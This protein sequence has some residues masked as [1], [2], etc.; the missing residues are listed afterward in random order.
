MR[1]VTIQCVCGW[2]WRSVAG[3]TRYT[4]RCPRCS[5]SSGF[6]RVDGRLGSQKQARVNGYRGDGQPRVAVL[7]AKRDSI[8]KTI[9]GC[10]VWDIDRDGRKWPGGATV[11]AHPPCRAWGRL[12]AFARPRED[13]K[14]LARLAV[15]QV[16]TWGGVLEHPAGSS[17][18]ADQKLPRPGA[19]FDAF[20]GWTL[21]VI[22]QAWGHRA[23][24]ATW[25]YIVGCKPAHVPSMP[26]VIGEATHVVTTSKR[27]DGVSKPELKTPERE[28]TPPAFAA[29]LVQLSGRCR[30]PSPL[31][32][33]GVTKPG[34]AAGGMFAEATTWP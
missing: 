33:S 9:P 29:W 15:L 24:K 12:R 34:P 30:V 28:A 6:T 23:E 5:R 7:F 17:L 26:W 13:E 22:Q 31:P 18:W 27:K 19:G 2:R 25:L 11:V 3:M 14:D 21:K 16:R 32:D 4:R 10:N 8:Y 1:R 20:G